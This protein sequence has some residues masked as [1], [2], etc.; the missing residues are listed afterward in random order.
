MT[1][2]TAFLWGTGISLGFCVGLVAWSLLR[3]LVI[4][5]EFDTMKA[6]HIES[7]ELLKRRNALTEDM[8]AQV[9]WI[10]RTIDNGPNSS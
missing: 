8:I 1:F 7:N 4:G 2:V 5:K 3:P 10:A 6:L 9:T